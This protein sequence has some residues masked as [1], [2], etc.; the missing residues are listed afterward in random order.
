MQCKLAMSVCMS[1]DCAPLLQ[2]TTASWLLSGKYLA[3]KAVRSG[4]GHVDDSGYIQGRS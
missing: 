1:S 2:Q 3:G 4:F